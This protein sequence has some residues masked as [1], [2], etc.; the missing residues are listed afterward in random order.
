MAAVFATTDQLD[1]WLTHRRQTGQDRY[2]EWWEGTYR[3]VTGP[4]PEH[5]ELLDALAELLGP[6]A[7][8]A[9]LKS[10]APANIGIDKDDCRVP[11]RAFYEPGTP[12]T[13]PAFLS[14]AVLVIEVLSPGERPGEKLDFYTEWGVK[15]YLEIDL[16]A[17]TVRLLV[18]RDTGEWEQIVD[19][20][21]LPFG[22]RLSIITTE[23]A[24]LDLREFRP[25]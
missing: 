9:G 20:E 7:R 15:E 4:S 24:T 22:A 23:T 19:S 8:A 21:L 3:V 10:S 13:S 16:A 18:H 5:G 12:R 2:D 25:L 1:D 17:A 6:V 14:T 11:D